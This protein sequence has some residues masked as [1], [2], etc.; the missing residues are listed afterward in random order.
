MKDITKRM[1][2]L[3]NQDP[4]PLMSMGLKIAEELGE[5]SEAINFIK[6]YLPHKQLKEP[7]EGE[8]ADVINC[9]I[10][11]L[12]KAYPEKSQEEIYSLLQEQLSKKADK[13]EQVIQHLRSET[14]K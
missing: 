6:G 11:I 9:A 8:V 14:D 7:L 2:M 12:V 4:K 13:W 10:T 1:I 5:L 3:A